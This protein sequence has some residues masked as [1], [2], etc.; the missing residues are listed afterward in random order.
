MWQNFKALLE[1]SNCHHRQNLQ[2]FCKNAC[3]ILPMV[4]L[5]FW[6]Y[7]ASTDQKKPLSFLL[8]SVLYIMLYFP[9]KL[10]LLLS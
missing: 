8:F 2:F 9:L 7:C 5:I 4:S 6:I 1:N 10:Y 3:I